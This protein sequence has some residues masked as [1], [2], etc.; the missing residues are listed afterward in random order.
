MS[1]HTRISLTVPERLNS[2]LDAISRATGISR[3]ALVSEL[4]SD[5]V[6]DIFHL[7]QD[8]QGPDLESGVT[9]NSGTTKRMRGASAQEIQRSLGVIMDY[10]GLGSSDDHSVH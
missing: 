10:L 4:L 2:R 6:S 8:P 9:G 5:R 7:L 3:S 1:K